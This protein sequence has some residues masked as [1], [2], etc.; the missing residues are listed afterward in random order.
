MRKASAA[1][2]C[3]ALDKLTDKESK[4]FII[5]QLEIVGNDAS[6][7][8]LQP[9]LS[10]ERLCDPAARTLVMINTPASKK[11]LLD[12]LQNASASNKL[13]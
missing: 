10:D 3:R 8:S 4:A 7:K 5:R 12:A 13:T 6:V 1:A 11:A 9:Y 2:Y